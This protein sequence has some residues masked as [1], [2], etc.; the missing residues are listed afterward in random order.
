MSQLLLFPFRSHAEHYLEGEGEECASYYQW[1][2]RDE[3]GVGL[4]LESKSNPLEIKFSSH[5]TDS[6]L[7]LTFIR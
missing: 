1:L 4:Y 3:E 7:E 2:Q 6:D 5:R